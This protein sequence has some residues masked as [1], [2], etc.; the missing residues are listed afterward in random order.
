MRLGKSQV[1]LSQALAHRSGVA[2]E[3]TH[4]HDIRHSVSP[5]FRL[6]VGGCR[7]HHCHSDRD[8]ASTASLKKFETRKLFMLR[9][10]L[11]I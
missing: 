1:S 2:K 3:L 4:F 9:S 7:G 10:G 8:F 6:D 11:E 5:A